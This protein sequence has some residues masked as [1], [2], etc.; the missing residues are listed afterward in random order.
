MSSLNYYNPRDGDT[1]G[2]DDDEYQIITSLQSN[3]G[4][5]T[6]SAPFTHGVVIDTEEDYVHAEFQ[7]NP[8]DSTAPPSQSVEVFDDSDNESTGDAEHPIPEMLANEFMQEHTRPFVDWSF[9]L[10]ETNPEVMFPV[11]ETLR[12][13]AAQLSSIYPSGCNIV[14]M[15]NISRPS[16]YAAPHGFVAV[17]DP[18]QLM[19]PLLTDRKFGLGTTVMYL[20]LA[21]SAPMD[22]QLIRKAL[23]H[24]SRTHSLSG[25]DSILGL[26]QKKAIV[27][28]RVVDQYALIVTAVFEDIAA[29][30][31]EYAER[32]F[33]EKVNVRDA[34]LVGDN[35]KRIQDMAIK[36][37]S[38]RRGI[39][40]AAASELGYKRTLEESMFSE[41]P[42]HGFAYDTKGN[43]V[44]YMSN[45]SVCNGTATTFFRHLSPA[46]GYVELFGGS[47]PWYGKAEAMWCFPTTMRMSAKAPKTASDP[48]APFIVNVDDDTDTPCPGA[49]S[50]DKFVP[51]S[52]QERS[53]EE[54]LGRAYPHEEAHWFPISC[55]MPSP[56]KTDAFNLSQFSNLLL[57]QI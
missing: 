38:R 44:T 15:P 11:E 28:G 50:L 57:L 33:S 51:R 23:R 36:A 41:T 47:M 4:R 9:T 27:N 26:Y 22:A 42:Y 56:S 5:S 12:P 14:L 7:K 52:M 53:L 35:L 49:Q 55:V 29:D 21:D 45:A 30:F 39:L 6:R 37:K 25:E 20:E 17:F 24:A 3:A 48:L 16:Q 13:W 1:D 43:Q 31:R 2:D 34:F 10:K 8:P 46:T 40:A 19:H 32:A 54:S 18:N